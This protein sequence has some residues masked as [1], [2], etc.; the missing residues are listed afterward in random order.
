[1]KHALYILA[2][3]AA[4]VVFMCIASG[5]TAPMIEKKYDIT[6]YQYGTGDNNVSSEFLK[7]TTVEPK[8]SYK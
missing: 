7:E 2:A 4:A 5:C 6:V 8:V 1:V 3:L